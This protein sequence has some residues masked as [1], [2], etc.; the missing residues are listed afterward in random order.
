ML[1]QIPLLYK[2]NISLSKSS[3]PLFCG[4]FSSLLFKMIVQLK[5]SVNYFVAENIKKNEINIEQKRFMC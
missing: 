3:H 2:L 5:L 4:H 1:Q